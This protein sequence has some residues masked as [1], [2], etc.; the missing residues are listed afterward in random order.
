MREKQAKGLFL[1]P[2]EG[3]SRHHPSPSVMVV[4][5]SMR[6]IPNKSDEWSIRE[7]TMKPIERRG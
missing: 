5:E 4:T 1:G 6:L 2:F 3:Q 7:K